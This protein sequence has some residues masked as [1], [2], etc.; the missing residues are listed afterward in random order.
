MRLIEFITNLAAKGHSS[1]TSTQVQE[2][3]GSSTVAIRAALRRL[4]KRGLVAQPISGFYIIVPP[5]YRILGCRPA[6]HFIT[7]LMNYIGGPYYVGLLTA[8]QYYGAAHHRPQQY[9]IITNQKRRAIICGNIK[10]V[11]VTK[12]SIAQ[13]PIQKISTSHNILIVSTPE[14]TAMDLIIY[15]NRCGGLDNVLTVITELAGKINA[16]KLTKLASETKEITW[17]QR[18]GYLLESI[19]ASNLSKKLENEIR[20]RNIQV[21]ILMPIKKS[22]N[23][24]H[25][26]QKTV[27]KFRKKKNS[28]LSQFKNKKWKLILNKKLEP[29]V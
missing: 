28:S 2:A 3:L 25:F 22:K 24:I 10:I 9:Q 1:F 6:E 21:R 29:D 13:V 7:D 5:E 18:L 4:K 16:K 17:V 14:A 8:A 19:N 12:K 20:K 15:A 26:N 23:I 27:A 11:F